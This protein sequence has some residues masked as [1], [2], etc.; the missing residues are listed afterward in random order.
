M[1]I[2]LIAL[3]LLAASGLLAQTRFFVGARMGYP[4]PAP[5]AMYAAPPAPLAAYVAPS[6]GPGYNW[7]AG[8]WYP[9]GPRYAWHGGYWTRPAFAG[10]RW[11]APRYAARRYYGGHWR[12]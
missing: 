10:A 9:V 11:I 3:T 7:V 12:R 4:V 6:P 5:V 8:Y 2:K 1:K